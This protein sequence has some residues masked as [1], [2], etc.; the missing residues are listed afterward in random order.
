[1]KPFRDRP[2]REKL[3]IVMTVTTLVAIVAAFVAFVVYDHFTGD[4]TDMQ[5][6][7]TRYLLA[8][9]MLSTFCGAGALLIADR[10][11]NTISNP[12]HRLAATA[13]SFAANHDYSVRV[14]VTSS[15]EIGTLGAA[16]NQML[17]VI[18]SREVELKAAEASLQQ[19]AHELHLEVH[20]RENAQQALRDNEDTLRRLAFYDQLT[21]LPNRAL[22]NDRLELAIAQAQRSNRYVAVMFID[23]DRFKLI[24]DS[25]GHSAGDA[26]LRELADRIKASLRRSD[27]LARLGGD[28]FIVLLP[29]LSDS[30]DAATVAQKILR[31]VSIPFSVGHQEWYAT[32]SIGISLSPDDGSDAETL[33][34]NA[35]AAMY[36]AKDRGRDGYEMYTPELHARALR[37]VTLENELRMAMSRGEFVMHYQPLLDFTTGAIRGAEA[38]IRWQHPSRGLLLPAEFIPVAEETG[39]IVPIGQWAIRHACQAAKNWQTATG[40]K[41]RMSVNLAARQFQHVDLIDQI[42]DILNETGLDASLLDIEI[43]ES[44]A[45]IQTDQTTA[46]L[47]QLKELGVSVSID[48]FGTGHSSLGTLKRFPIDTLK[49]DRTFVQ[50][51]TTDRRDSALVQAIVALGEALA[52]KVVAEGVETEEQRTLLKTHGCDGFQGFVFSKAI[53]SED[54][55]QMIT[56]D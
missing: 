56:P 34:K 55:L 35:D 24:N 11:Q 37:R 16:F 6:R 33:I 39:L 51:I 47:E 5:S 14:H 20:E 1:M 42:R 3:L 50:D 4:N 45:M 54:F 10:L 22:F 2:V 30:T 12:L 17:D 19:R 48:D 27:T 38:L 26:L 13:S 31:A 15:D 43:T 40:R 32:V 18:E 25:L 28:E 8:I 41:L 49:I 46:I 29:S 36:R 9:F 23:V 52:V 21:G 7:L 53:P 44:S